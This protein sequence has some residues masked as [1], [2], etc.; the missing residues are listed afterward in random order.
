MGFVSSFFR[1]MKNL[2]KEDE[3]IEKEGPCTSYSHQE[4]ENEHGIYL[5]YLILSKY[6]VEYKSQPRAFKE[7]L[8]LLQFIQLKE[9]RRSYNKRGIK[10]NRFLLPTYE[11][12]STTRSWARELEAFFLLHPVVER[13]AVEVAVL[14]LE[15]EA[16]VWW[17]SHLSHARV[18]TFAEFTQRLIITFDREISDEKNPT[19][20]WDET[21]T[22]AVTTL[23]EQPSTSANGLAI[24]LEE[25]TIAAIQGD[26]KFHQGMNKVPLSISE[27]IL[28]D[29]GNSSLYDQE[30][31]HIANVE[32]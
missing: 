10:G 18:N 5:Y 32:Q 22:S 2:P 26:P 12:S 14:H 28:E 21:S 20:T 19:P 31:T 25:R 23:E 13:E 27:N 16:N 11:G 8:A 6:L 1:S 9:E 3:K 17:F 15:G 29:C 7:T 4:E 24:S 30:S